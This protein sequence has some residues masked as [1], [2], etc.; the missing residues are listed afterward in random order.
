MRVADFL[1]SRKEKFV[2]GALSLLVDNAVYR[3]ASN[4]SIFSSS[5]SRLSPGTSAAANGV[6]K[7]EAHDMLCFLDDGRGFTLKDARDVLCARNAANSGNRKARGESDAACSAPLPPPLASS[8]HYGNLLCMGGMRVGADCLV[9]SKALDGTLSCMLLS[10]TLLDLNGHANHPRSPFVAWQLGVVAAAS[11]THAGRQTPPDDAAIAIPKGSLEVHAANV[12]AILQ[13]TPFTSSKE[14]LDQFG[15]VEGRQ[16]TLVLCMNLWAAQR[17]KPSSL[18]GG[19]WS[20]SAA[21]AAAQAL[22]ATATVA[23]MEMELDFETAGDDI[24]LRVPPPHDVP[25]ASLRA[26]VA[27]LYLRPSTTIAV[28][29]RQV[30][31]THPLNTLGC[32]GTY[33][34]SFDPSRKQLAT[35]QRTR[36]ACAQRVSALKAEVALL[37]A[38]HAAP[39]RDFED[40]HDSGGGGGGGG[41][42]GGTGAAKKAKAEADAC[43]AEQTL[44]DV[45]A[46]LANVAAHAPQST[47]LMLTLGMNSNS[48]CL[49]G[50]LVY[51]AGRLIKLYERMGPQVMHSDPFNPEAAG[52]VVAFVD[53]PHSILAPLMHRQ[54]FHSSSDYGVLYALMAETMQSFWAVFREK[55]NIVN[56]TDVEMFWQ[57]FG[58]NR[59]EWRTAPDAASTTSNAVRAQSLEEHLVVLDPASACALRQ[60]D[61]RGGVATVQPAL[62]EEEEP[63][64]SESDSEDESDDGDVQ[65]DDDDD[66]DDDGGVDGNAALDDSDADAMNSAEVAIIPDPLL[67]DAT[68]KTKHS[69]DAM[70]RALVV[71]LTS[72]D[73]DGSSTEVALPPQEKAAAAAVAAPLLV[74]PLVGGGTPV[75]GPVWDALKATLEQVL[76]PHRAAELDGMSVELLQTTSFTADCKTYANALKKCIE[77]GSDAKRAIAIANQTDAEEKLKSI[78]QKTQSLLKAINGGKDS[79][80]PFFAPSEKEGEKEDQTVSIVESVVEVMA[81]QPAGWLR[82]LL[83]PGRHPEPPP[84]K[85]WYAPTVAAASREFDELQGPQPA[86][87]SSAPPATTKDSEGSK[88][89]AARFPKKLQCRCKRGRCRECGCCRQCGCLCVERKKLPRKKAARPANAG[90]ASSTASASCRSANATDVAAADDAAVIVAGNTPAVQPSLVRV[91]ARGPSDAD[92]LLPGGFTRCAKIPTSNKSRCPCHRGKCAH[93][94]VCKQ[95]SCVCAYGVYLKEQKMLT[96]HRAREAAQAARAASRG[97]GS[98]YKESNIL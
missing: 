12:Q 61:H 3:A 89:R 86:S 31:P 78:R 66:D 60:Q 34:V 1:A 46:E 18:R 73:S 48:R 95:C 41:A 11:D 82:R 62:L 38:E 59:P 80:D 42:G 87:G 96:K 44:H 23:E 83:Q 14:L 75:A 25:T 67:G 21:A 55:R 17:P 58:Y 97:V 35:L 72:D 29:G 39:A 16:G 37:T 9:F 5:S 15:R 71:D 76:P 94:G 20:G 54:A 88:L 50:M 8:L 10:Q 26:Y 77:G 27:L 6:G 92:D 43:E 64:I 68:L 24:L 98:K 53:L 7:A 56:R 13:V 81:K 51:H 52:G 84:T 63:E 57:S 2:F 65:L 91:R 85:V 36:D 33:I 22:D 47:P 74:R 28:Q 32:R 79:E 45:D 49:G 4:L 30:A 90:V 93:C 70:V 19:S 69:R 40:K